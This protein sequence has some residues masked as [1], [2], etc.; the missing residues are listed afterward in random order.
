MGD[1]PERRHAMSNAPAEPDATRRQYALFADEPTFTVMITGKAIRIARE[2]RGLSIRA[3]ARL[4]GVDAMTILRAEQGEQISKSSTAGRL[5]RA[6]E[7]DAEVAVQLG[8]TPER[9]ALA[10]ASVEQGTKEHLR[11]LEPWERD[12]VA[13]YAVRMHPGG[14]TMQQVAELL[15]LAEGTVAEAQAS[16]CAKLAALAKQPGDEGEEVRDW[17]RN[18]LDV[19]AARRA[20]EGPCEWMAGGEGDE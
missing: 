3:L 5:S 19:G 1:P 13:R 4:S 9:I 10:S 11:D 14:L 20:H 6:L 16:A 17:V 7:G 8:M 15:D 12:D 18:V 2:A